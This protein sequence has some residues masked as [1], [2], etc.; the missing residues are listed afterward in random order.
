MSDEKGKNITS[1]M[2]IDISELKAGL[3]EANRQ[4]KLANAEFKNATAGLDSWSDSADGLSAKLRQLGKLEEEEQKKLQIL[5]QE[6]AAVAE[7]QG[8]NSVAAQNLAT[9]INNQEATVKRIQKEYN[10]YSQRLQ[11]VEA[12]SAQATSATGKLTAEINDQEQ[13]LAQLTAEYKDVVLEQGKNSDAAQELA[14]K[15]K[16]LNADLQDNKD[17]MKEADDAADQLTGGMDDVGSA[18][19]KV[20]DGFTVAKGAL[21]GFIANMAT[22]AISKVG[23]FASSLM[24]LTE[25]TREYRE[26]M[27]KVEGSAN[28][29]GYSIEF[30]KE[31][32]KEFYTYLRDDQ[33]AT[34]AITNL[35]GLGL[36]TED[37]TNLANGA[38]SVWTAYGDS[39]PIESLTESM[40]E[41]INVSKVTGVLADTINWASRSNEQWSSILGNN[42]AAQKAFSDAI[43]AGL[44]VEDAFNAALAEITDTSERAN[45]V[46]EMLNTTYG[47]SKKTYDEVSKSITDANRAEAELK[48]TQA[49]L[50]ESLEPVSTEFKRMKNEALKALT[51]AIKD[52]SGEFK[53]RLEGID[54]R[55][56]ADLIGSLLTGAAK[57]LKLVVNNIG[58]IT[59]GIKA[60]A[61]AWLT[62]KTAQLAANGVTTAANAVLAITTASTTAA[63]TA[64]VAHTAATNASTVATKALSLAQKA[65]PWGLVAGLVA[66]V[67]VAFTSYISKSKETEEATDANSVATR[68]LADEYDRLSDSLET[69]AQTRQDNIANAEAEAESA[70]ILLDRLEQLSEK[71]N[72]SNAE[73]QM[74]AQYVEQLNQLM[75][76]LN[77]QYDEEADKLNMSTEAI[78]EQIQANKELILAKAAQEQ[79]MAVAQD[80]AKVESQLAKATQQ[81]EENQ[82]ALNK[83][84]E[85]YNAALEAKRNHEVRSSKEIERTRKSLQDAKAAYEET[86]KTVEGLEEDLKSLK[87][88][89]NSTDEYAQAKLTAAEMEETL[90]S[91]I[92]SAEKAGIQVPQALADGIREGNY[93]LPSSVEE[94]SALVDFYNLE[95]KAA[96]AGIQIPASISSGIQSGSLAPATAVQQMENLISFNDMLTEAGLAGSAVPEYLSQGIASGQYSVPEA[97]QI[98]KDLVTY[99]DMLDKASQAGIA[100]PDRITLGVA[101]GKMTPAAAVAEINDLM[102]GEANSAAPEMEQAGDKSAT[103]FATGISLGKT[104]IEDTAKAAVRAG[105][106]AG[107]AEAKNSSAVG[108][109]MI[110]GIVAGINAASW[111]VGN[112]MSSIARAALSVAMSEIDAHSPSRKFKKLVGMPISQGIALGIEEKSGEAIGSVKNMLRST[113]DE[114]QAMMGE[115]DGGLRGVV[116]G[117]IA[118]SKTAVTG[119]SSRPQNGVQKSG[120]GN[121]YVFNQTNN[122]PKAL[123]S[124]TIYRNTQRQIK[125]LKKLQGV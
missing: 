124:L 27:A 60:A 84:Q 31:Q 23:E 42:A 106:D 59:T 29:F 35:M 69:N 117:T 18:T 74:M 85:E 55:G 118:A 77:L 73:K 121:T 43:A 21:A 119:Y 72:K 61:A 12:N 10:T 45:V 104:L 47:D 56:G 39:I 2:S 9:R 53:E 44:P 25:E 15:I 125:Q 41:T 91:L 115:I 49:E 105:A 17:R 95:Q 116:S 67:V 96:E 86:G 99:G 50:A 46:A 101:S 20:K 88:E 26:M 34:N 108:T 81:H 58:P 90:T 8:E 48:E 4:I 38:I 109:S 89:Y 5:K 114:A 64:T 16:S 63:T 78:R 112:A 111:K 97:V 120:G 30:A 51:P 94:M 110:D 32:Y 62:Y 28:T 87:E 71:E 6:Y 102:I 68:E 22:S 103:S 11:E 52:A 92:S 13:E 79:L 19:T 24:N 100:V 54:W 123:D 98:M 1:K 80:M 93:A 75:P 33:M 83:A 66:G 76:E 113:L 40:T 57:G 107:K 82:K 36:A 14:S 65:T 70:G 122:S 3:Q 7:Q 37:V